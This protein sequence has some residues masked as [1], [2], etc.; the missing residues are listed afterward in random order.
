MNIQTRIATAAAAP[1]PSAPR[2]PAFDWAD[3][4]AL[5][6][7]LTENERMI[8]GSARAFCDA[9][10]APPSAPPTATRPTTRR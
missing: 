5:D 7:A 6:A 2:W 3:P 8:R 4:L 1:A 10:L 9:E